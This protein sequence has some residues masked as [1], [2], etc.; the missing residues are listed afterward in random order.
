MTNYIMSYKDE[1]Y[2]ICATDA[3]YKLLYDTR[4]TREL[5]MRRTRNN[6]TEDELLYYT[7]Y[8][9]DG[10]CRVRDERDTD[11]RLNEYTNDYSTYVLSSAIPRTVSYKQEQGC[12]H[13]LNIPLQICNLKTLK[14][15]QIK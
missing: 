11:T 10:R 2:R 14:F 7:R 6:N 3:I 15:I 4:P 12:L 1:R 8:T 5:N 9:S 13:S